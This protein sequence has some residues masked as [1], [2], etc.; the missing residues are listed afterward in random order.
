MR[1]HGTPPNT[2]HTHT[3]AVIGNMVIARKK[4]GVREV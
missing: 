3:E 4:K 1:P 2:H